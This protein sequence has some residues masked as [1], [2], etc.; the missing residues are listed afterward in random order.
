MFRAA[1]FW[2]VVTLAVGQNAAL[3]CRV[4]CHPAEATAPGCQ[5]EGQPTSQSITG[6]CD[7]IVVGAFV[8]EE[9]RRAASARDTEDAVVV[10]RLGFIPPP[11]D[12]R[13]G[14]VSRQH[15]PP[16]ARPLVLALRI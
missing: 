13:S 3:L 1:A 12:T 8:R 7:D 9:A 4:S 2:I 11:T 6:N 10:P 5:H 15:P 14:D 16:E